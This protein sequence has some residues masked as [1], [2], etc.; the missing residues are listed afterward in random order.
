MPVSFDSEKHERTR[1]SMRIEGRTGEDIKTCIQMHT[2]NL[3]RAHNKLTETLRDRTQKERG[4]EE[5]RPN[6]DT[7]CLSLA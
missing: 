3:M 4:R 6:G 2:S 7:A 5:R 1:T